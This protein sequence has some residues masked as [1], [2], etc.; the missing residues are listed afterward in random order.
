[1]S[2]IVIIEG[3]CNADF[4]RQIAEDFA[5]ESFQPLQDK[6]IQNFLQTWVIPS[7]FLA[8]F[9]QQ[10]GEKSE[11]CHQFS[12]SRA[13]SKQMTKFPLGVFPWLYLGATIIEGKTNGE[14]SGQYVQPLKTNV[15]PSHLNFHFI[16]EKWIEYHHHRY[17]PPS[18]QHLSVC[19][20]SNLLLWLREV[21]S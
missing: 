19:A 10:G 12:L 8:L 20:L 4:R 17:H 3:H 21:H 14:Q 6:R 11:R 18:L 7:N 5:C 1:M 13:P 9:W 15:L 2:L 16:S